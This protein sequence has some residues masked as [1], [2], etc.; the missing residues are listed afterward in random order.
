MAVKK[1]AASASKRAQKKKRPPPRQL[2]P[3][4]KRERL[5]P[6]SLYPLTFDQA[7]DAI[8]AVPTGSSRK[9]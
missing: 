7:L 3:K 8:I 2:P 5:K 4:G 6:V 1:K 9:R